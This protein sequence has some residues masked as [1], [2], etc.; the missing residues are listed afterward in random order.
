MLIKVAQLANQLWLGDGRVQTG[1]QGQM[2][3]VCVGFSIGIGMINGAALGSDLLLSTFVSFVHISLSLNDRVEPCITIHILRSFLH[4]ISYPTA[5]LT[6]L[7]NFTPHAL[8]LCKDFFG[9]REGGGRT[10][11]LLLR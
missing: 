2:R 8:M 5:L 7:Q 9:A 6:S 11:P 4:S 3:T 10:K 1:R